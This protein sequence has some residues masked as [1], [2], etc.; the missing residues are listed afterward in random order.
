M[1]FALVWSAVAKWELRP[2][3]KRWPNSTAKRPPAC[4]KL[5]QILKLPKLVCK[6]RLAAEANALMSLHRLVSVSVQSKKIAVPV[7]CPGLSAALVSNQ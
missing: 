1:T 2:N 5:K 6:K 7:R 3:C 4:A